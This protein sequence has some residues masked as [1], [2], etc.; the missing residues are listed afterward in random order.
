[1]KDEREFLLLMKLIDCPFDN[2]GLFKEKRCGSMKDFENLLHYND[3][4]KEFRGWFKTLLDEGFVFCCGEEPRGHGQMVKVYAVDRKKI[5]RLIK[6]KDT[7]KVAINFF[8]KRT[9][10][11]GVIAEEP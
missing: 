2:R 8:A 11:P 9:I 10:L 1:M 7:Y 5:F 3:K 6:E 4:N